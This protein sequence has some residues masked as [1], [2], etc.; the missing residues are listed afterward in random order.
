MI[1]M[2]AHQVITNCF[3]KQSSNHR[4]V[5]TTRQSQQYLFIANLTLNQFYLVVHKIC[6]V[7]VS[8]RF[9]GIKY[10]RLYSLLNSLDIICK[11]RQF[12]SASRFIV[13]GSYNRKSHCI[14]SR[15]YVNGNAINHI[16]RSAIDNNTLYVG[17]CFQ[18]FY[19]DVVRIN[20][21]IN[22]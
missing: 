21:T 2:H 22:S 3:Q 13:T 16:V 5:N 17:Q 10:E 4:A 6:H 19:S 20:L 8:F 12:H 18:F 15:I 11:F 9:A 1:D 7:P 14:N